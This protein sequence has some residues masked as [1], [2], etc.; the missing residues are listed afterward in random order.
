MG[1]VGPGV[2]PGSWLRWYAYPLGGTVRRDH[3][4]NPAFV[5][6]TS[7]LAV[8]FLVFLYLVDNLPQLCM[9]AVIFFI[10]LKNIKM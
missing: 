10:F 3:T 2:R 4:Q 6:S 1:P 9:H 7:K 5:P 8:R